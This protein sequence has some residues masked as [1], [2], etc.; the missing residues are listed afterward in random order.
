M[1]SISHLEKKCITILHEDFLSGA[2]GEIGCGGDAE[3]AA[4]R[5]KSCSNA[6]EKLRAVS[7]H[8][9]ITACIRTA[10]SYEEPLVAEPLA[11]YPKSPCVYCVCRPDSGRDGEGLANM[12][13]REP[14]LKEPE[15]GQRVPPG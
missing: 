7:Q 1:G 9:L 2:V 11:I 8:M 6:W 15:E 14:G 12:Q 13:R 3:A 5:I 4:G 10:L